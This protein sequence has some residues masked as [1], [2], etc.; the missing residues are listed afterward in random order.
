MRALDLL[1]AALEAVPA[2][3]GRVVSW[4]VLAMVALTFVNVVLRYLYGLS[5]VT[6]YE[7]VLYGFAIVLTA[8]AGWTLQRDEHVRVDIIYAALPPRGRAAVNLAGAAV[9]LF[10]FLWFL[11]SA[12]LPYVARSW[13]IREG[14]TEISG[15]PYLYVL[16]GFILVFVVVLALQGAAF[17]LRALRTLMTGRA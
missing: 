12:G 2:A 17:V 11:W 6:L 4:L 16:K 1:I 7:A 15:I 5:F 14:S 10:P 8:T 9:F 13:A 3:V